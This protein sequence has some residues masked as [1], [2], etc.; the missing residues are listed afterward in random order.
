MIKREV[1]ALEC[2]T[3]ERERPP[4]VPWNIGL[5]LEAREKLERH[6]GQEDLEDALQN[7]FLG[8]GNAIG[9]FDDVDEHRVQDV[10]GVIW[11]RSIDKDI[12]DVQGDGPPRADAQGLRV[13]RSPG[14]SLFRGH[15]GAHRRV[16]R[17]LSRV[18]DRV[19]ALRAGLD[20]ARLGQPD[21]GL[22]RPSALCARSA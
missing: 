1:V 20:D 21:D 7:H 2:W 16:W 22:L 19:F 4:Y 11:D 15:P 9:F 12:G 8:L 14:R 3:A 18:P 13:S 17:S 10:F 5:T 6:F